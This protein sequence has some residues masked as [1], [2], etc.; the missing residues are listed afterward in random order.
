VPSLRIISEILELPTR[1]P[2]HI[3]RA[4]APPVRRSVWLRVI[5][6]TGAEGWGEAAANAYYGE[7]VDTVLALVP[8]FE[9]V[10]NRST[11]DITLLEPLERNIE[12]A[13]RDNPAARVAVSAALH[14]LVGKRLGVPVWRLWGLDPHAM[15][16][17]SFTLGLD[18]PEAVLQKLEEAASYPILK[19]KVGSSDDRR[20]LEL[21][22]EAAPGKRVRIDANTGWSVAEA[23]A[24]LPALEELDIEL[25]EQP[26][27]ADD[28]DS[29][30]RLRGR[31]RIPIVADESCRVAADI[32][33]L[34]GA[35]DGIN[36]KLEKCGSL[37]EAV[38]MVHVARAHDMHVM[39]GCM[40]STTLAMAAAMQLAPL[41]DFVDLDG[42]ALL[43]HDPFT[44]PHLQPDGQLVLNDAPGLGV[45]RRG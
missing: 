33:R 10:L 20:L 37:R 22:R 15:P 31:S 35:V 14:D 25:I 7:S 19:M 42:A 43:A 3:A 24:L 1:H 39:L 13:V 44:G 12:R 29:F 41:V 11:G 26:F 40:L 30:R 34:A 36:I 6:E 21:V 32:P 23:L 17:S 2:F 16:A 27:P 5:D 9:E 38:R 4:A 45:T 28:L 8:V 18:T